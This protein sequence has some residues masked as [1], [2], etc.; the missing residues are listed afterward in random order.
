MEFCP[1]CG[2]VLLP[3]TVQGRKVLKCRVCGYVK[4]DS[5]GNSGYRVTENIERKPLDKISIVDVDVS[6]L[7]IVPFVCEN[8]GNDKAYA[9]EVQ[10]RAGDEPATRFYVCTKCRKVYR[11]YA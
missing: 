7:P 10:T 3:V 6:A 2:A 1:Q 11:E 4:E 9:Y 5:S 8:C